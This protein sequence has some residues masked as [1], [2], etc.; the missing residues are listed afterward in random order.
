MSGEEKAGQI[1]EAVQEYEAAKVGLAHLKQKV[2]RVART[3][4]DC[5]EALSRD[6][7]FDRESIEEGILKLPYGRNQNSPAFLL[8]QTGLIAL[9]REK[10]QAEA[11]LKKASD[12]MKALEIT[13][14][15]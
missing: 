5:S 10:E 14:L 8:D 15:E 12:A 4:R 11:R 13:N 3:Y 6:F 1:S 2:S 9:L 7:P